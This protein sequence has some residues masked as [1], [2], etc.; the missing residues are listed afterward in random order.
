MKTLGIVGGIGPESTIEYY[1]FILEGCRQRVTDGRAPHII[2]DSID[3]NRAIAMLDA[4]DRAGVAAYLG[5]AVERLGRAGADVALMA[6]NTAHIVFDEVQ[7]QS[8]IPLI[9]IVQAACDHAKRL[10]L[11]RLALL[12]TGF[13]MRARFYPDVFS[14]AG[15]D[16]V[17]PSDGEMAYIHD[18]YINELLRN[19]FLPETQGGDARGHRSHETSRR[20]R[21]RDS[22]R[23]RA[24]AAPARH[25]TVRS[26][27]SR[28]DDDPRRA[29]GD[30]G[31]GVTTRAT[32][33]PGYSDR[34]PTIMAIG[35]PIQSI[36]MIAPMMDGRSCRGRWRTLLSGR[37]TRFITSQ[38]TPP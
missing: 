24:A 5:E 3:V 36:R 37:T 17:R 1:R 27:V 18:K 33:P 7:R 16:L 29:G 10:G 30:G 20:H 22:R 6:A 35:R 26:P 11:T 15:I 31:A 9:S 38:T 21:R 19:E 14:R 28:Y 4:D 34:R 23:D 2:I 25:R 12:G 8:P 13:T 32:S